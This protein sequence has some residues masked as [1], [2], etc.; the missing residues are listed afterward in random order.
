VLDVITEHLLTPYGLRTLSQEDPEYHGRFDGDMKSRDMAYHN[1]TVWPWLIGP[2]CDAIRS[3]AISSEEADAAVHAA[4]A[5]LVTSLDHG[6]MGQVAEIY[7]GNPPHEPHGCP[8]Q[9][10]SVAELLRVLTPTPVGSL[11]TNKNCI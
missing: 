4:T 2:Y 8:A 9:A 11:H 10:W 3:L 7:D 1:G 5:A 6:C